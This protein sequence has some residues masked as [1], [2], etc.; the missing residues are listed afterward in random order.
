MTKIRLSPFISKSP[1]QDILV[2]RP[3]Y[4]NDDTCITCGQASCPNWELCNG[5]RFTKR[6]LKGIFL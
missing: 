3:D 4:D 6:Q 2:N 1:D 5:H